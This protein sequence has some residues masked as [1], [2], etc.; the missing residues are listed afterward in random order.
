ML[1]MEIA[2]DKELLEEDGYD[3]DTSYGILCKN[4]EKANFVKESFK[5]G[6]LVY[7]GA[8][9]DKDFAYF[10]LIYLALKKCDWFKNCVS[11]WLLIQVTSWG[12]VSIEDFLK[13]CVDS[14]VEGFS[15]KRSIKSILYDF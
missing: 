10:G 1:K 6:H 3:W 8:G 12:E 15:Y 11:C 13:G 2:L 14:G 9:N 5:N 4:F 7:R